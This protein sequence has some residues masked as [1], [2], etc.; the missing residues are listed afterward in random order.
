VPELRRLILVYI[1]GPS[2]ERKSIILNI[3]YFQAN[4]IPI[5]RTSLDN[6]A[7]NC[8]KLLRL[9][10]SGGLTIL[11][12]RMNSTSKFSKVRKVR[13]R[14]LKF[15]YDSVESCSDQDVQSSSEE[16]F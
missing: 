1:V 5:S 2:E 11:A 14:P 7:D 13:S 10:A 12:G 16:D 15:D 9:S 8:P 3:H 6:L 4:K